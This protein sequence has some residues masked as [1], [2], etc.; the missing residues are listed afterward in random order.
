[1]ESAI[2]SRL[3]DFYGIWSANIELTNTYPGV[4][5]RPILARFCYNVLVW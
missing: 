1:M 2:E 5:I 3:V 4:C